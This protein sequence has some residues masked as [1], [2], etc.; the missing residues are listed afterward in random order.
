MVSDKLPSS[1][2]NIANLIRGEIIAGISTLRGLVLKD[3]V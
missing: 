3:C 2:D 1:R